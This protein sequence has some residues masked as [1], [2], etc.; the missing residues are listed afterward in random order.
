[1][2][3]VNVSAPTELR[4]NRFVTRPLLATDNEKDFEAWSSSIEAL[5]G[6]FGPESG[7]PSSDMTLEENAVDVA[8]HQK[9]HANNSSYAFTVMSTDNVRCLGCVY[10]SPAR[11]LG[12]EVELFWWV[13]SDESASGLD[14]VLGDAVQQWLKDDWPFRNV[15]CPG[16]SISWDAYSAL[17]DQPHW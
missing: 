13:R 2:L 14:A 1:M 8:W 17:Q 5:N 4:T 7:W 16:R 9:E 15:V 3:S 11:K 12:Y 10:L 6:V